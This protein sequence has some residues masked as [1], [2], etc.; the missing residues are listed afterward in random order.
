[1]DYFAHKVIRIISRVAIFT[2]D[3]IIKGRIFAVEDNDRWRN[4]V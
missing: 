1:M 2:V 3:G 4:K